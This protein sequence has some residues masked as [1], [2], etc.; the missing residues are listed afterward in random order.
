MCVCVYRYI[1]EGHILAVGGPLVP[2][3]SSQT[4]RTLLS[5]DGAGG[6]GRWPMNNTCEHLSPWKCSLGERKIIISTFMIP[7]TPEQ[8]HKYYTQVSFFSFGQT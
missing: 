6:A 1:F 3:P 4:A 5:Q 8:G 2:G 7:E